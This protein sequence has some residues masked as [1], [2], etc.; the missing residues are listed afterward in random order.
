VHTHTSADL[1]RVNQSRLQFPQ[2]R[3]SKV[4]R[5]GETE[6]AWW[7][8]GELGGARQ[9]AEER[10]LRGAADARARSTSAPEA[11]PPP[12]FC[13][14]EHHLK[15]QRMDYSKEEAKN[16]RRKSSDAGKIG[17]MP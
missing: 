5:S 2:T 3:Q 7:S 17:F 14:T 8:F 15:H 4:K 16:Y 6:R 12:A 10:E 1:D 9:A 11:E 13:T